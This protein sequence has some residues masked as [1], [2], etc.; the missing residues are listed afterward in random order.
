MALRLLPHEYVFV[1]HNLKSL[2][3]GFITIYDSDKNVVCL[4]KLL[5]GNIKSLDEKYVLV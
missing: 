3:A 4:L 2:L 5:L 1:V